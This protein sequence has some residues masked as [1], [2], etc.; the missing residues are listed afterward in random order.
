MLT[1]ENGDSTGFEDGLELGFE[2]LKVV[3]NNGRGSKIMVLA[4]Q[5]DHDIDQTSLA[6]L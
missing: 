5:T 4:N 6:D 3:R 1:F 2:G